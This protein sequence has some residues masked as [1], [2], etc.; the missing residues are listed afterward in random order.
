MATVPE[1]Y[2][3]LLDEDGPR[4]LLEALKL[5]GIR[6]IP[7]QKHNPIIL[8]WAKVLG[9]DNIVKDD[10]MA[11]CATAHAYVIVSSGKPLGFRNYDVIRALKY[12][13]WGNPVEGE[14]ELGDTLVFK[15]P[16]GGHVGLYVAESK[17]TYHVL[18][19]NQSNAY[20]FTEIA[21]DR[22]V[23]ARNLYEIGKPENV[24]RIFIDASGHISTNEQ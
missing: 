12:A 15:R 9:I 10:E 3:Y 1:K 18:G 8:N 4:M 13:E 2:K 20:G 14:P 5:V 22:L 21:K 16:E 24:R 11:W 6:E 7:G 23:A 17:T 19:G